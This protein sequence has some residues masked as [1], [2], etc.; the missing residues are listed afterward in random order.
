MNVTIVNKANVKE[1]VL[2]DL[3]KE[4]PLII[5]S[6]LEVP[7]G[8][9]AIVKPEQVALAFCQASARDVGS[10]VRIEV[11]ARSN[12]PRTSTEND[13]AKEI[14]EKVAAV[15]TNAGEDYSVDVRLY[16]MAIGVANYLPRN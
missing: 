6:V 3:A 5:S 14:L 4:L 15:I 11:F 7:G 2:D 1:C 13:R 9:M 12:D 8:R 10:D 16:L